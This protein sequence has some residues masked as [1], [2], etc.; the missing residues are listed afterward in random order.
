MREG[1]GP[2]CTRARGWSGRYHC[3]NFWKVNL[4]YWNSADIPTEACTKPDKKEESVQRITCVALAS[5]VVVGNAKHLREWIK[6]L[7]KPHTCQYRETHRQLPVH[8]RKT[9]LKSRNPL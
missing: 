9:L 8:N 3:S 7:P 1:Q 4:P 5:E 6:I 2:S